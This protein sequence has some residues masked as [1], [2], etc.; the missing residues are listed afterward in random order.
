MHELIKQTIEAHGGLDAWNRVRQ[1]SMSF[2]PSGPS[3]KQRGPVGE[4]FTQQLMHVTVQ[5]HEQKVAFDPFIKPGQL[6]LYGPER[7]AVVSSDGT[8]IEELIEPRRS[9]T[10]MAPGT[11]W[12]GPQVIYFVGYS[13]WMYITLP[14]SFLLD[15]V[16]VEEDETLIDNGETWRALKVTYPDTYPAHSTDQIHYFDNKGLMRRQDYTVDVNRDIT[17]AHYMY[18]HRTFDGLVFPTKRRIVLRGPDRSPLWDKPLISADLEDF[19]ITRVEE[20][21]SAEGKCVD[22]CD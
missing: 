19:K 18:D 22:R 12:T 14:Y 16:R 17:I 10:A 5:A 7:T 4:A 3:F 21:E 15:S 6:G 2:A 11:P 13:L 20:T 8:L 1:V 9:L